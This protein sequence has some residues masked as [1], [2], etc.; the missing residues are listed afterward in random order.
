MHFKQGCKNEQAIN[1][2]IYS[3]NATTVNDISA[4]GGTHSKECNTIAQDIW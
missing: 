2:Q 3:D 1:V 4:M